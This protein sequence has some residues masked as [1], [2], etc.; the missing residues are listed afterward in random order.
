MVHL[1]PSALIASLTSTML[2]QDVRHAIQSVYTAMVL[3]LINALIVL[4][5]SSSSITTV[6]LSAL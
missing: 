6:S 5:P 4:S 2:S 3:S 1:Q